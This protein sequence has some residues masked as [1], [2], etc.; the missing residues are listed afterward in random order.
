ME[1]WKQI[2][3]GI[4]CLWV[5]FLASLSG[6]RIRYC[7][8]LWYRLQMWTGSGVAMAVALLWLWL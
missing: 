2:Q 1:Q 3:L 6:L 4:M 8:E 7:S 5:Q